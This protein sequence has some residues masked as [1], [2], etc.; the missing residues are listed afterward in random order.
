MVWLEF[1]VRSREWFSIGD[2]KFWVVDSAQY[3]LTQRQKE[4]LGIVW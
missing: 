4:R 1:V 3:S 2:S